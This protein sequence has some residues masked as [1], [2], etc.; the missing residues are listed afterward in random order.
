MF[1]FVFVIIGIIDIF[2]SLFQFQ[3]LTEAVIWRKSSKNSLNPDTNIFLSIFRLIEFWVK[4]YI[5]CLVTRSVFFSNLLEI[6]FQS[7]VNYRSVSMNHPVS[8]SEDVDFPG[9]SIRIVPLFPLGPR[10]R[11]YNLEHKKHETP[12][13]MKNI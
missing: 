11:W 4:S 12:Y 7:H 13:T 6:F 1:L 5:F 9:K 2:I 3:E 10:P 8:Q